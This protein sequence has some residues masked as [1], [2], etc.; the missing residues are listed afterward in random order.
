MAAVQ[1]VDLQNLDV[2]NVFHRLHAFTDNFRQVFQHGEADLHFN[3]LG[4]QHVVGFVDGARPFRIN[5]ILLF[6][7]LRQQDFRIGFAF[8][9]QAGLFGC[10]FGSDADRFCIIGCSLFASFRRHRNGNRVFFRSLLGRHQFNGFLPFGALGFPHGNHF[11][12][13]F[14][15]LS[16]GAVSLRFSL[17]FFA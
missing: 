12:F 5:L 9:F 15:R 6:H 14:D 11:L 7:R 16:A 8:G 4:R 10:R 3:L 17:R 1:A 2:V 13:G